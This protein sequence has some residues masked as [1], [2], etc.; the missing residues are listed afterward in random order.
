MEPTLPG[1][2]PILGRLGSA[3]AHGVAALL[4]LAA[5]RIAWSIVANYRSPLRRC[6]GPCF[7]RMLPLPVPVWFLSQ[8][9]GVT[10]AP[11]SYIAQLT[12][13]LPT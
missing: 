13:Y 11:L 1:M 10:L 5:A 12:T 2:A 6:P 8:N 3:L 7:A 9:L 4:I